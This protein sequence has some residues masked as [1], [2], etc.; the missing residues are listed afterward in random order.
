MTLLSGNPAPLDPWA[1]WFSRH[2]DF[3]MRSAC[4]LLGGGEG[5]EDVVQEVFLRLAKGRAAFRGEARETTYLWGIT[6]NVC[7][8]ALRRRIRDRRLS[9]MNLREETVDPHGGG[10]NEKQGEAALLSEALGRLKSRH[11]EPLLLYYY[12][13]KSYAEIAEVLGIPEGTVKSRIHQ[14]KERVAALLAEGRFHDQGEGVSVAPS[15]KKR[16]DK[17]DPRRP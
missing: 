17:T 13:D 6:R 4:I 16:P 15:E 9:Q 1:D 7:R 14:A 5:A 8:E 3:V 12:Q 11:R 10:E 2:R